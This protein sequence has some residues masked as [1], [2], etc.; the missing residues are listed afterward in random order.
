MSKKTPTTKAMKNRKSDTTCPK[1]SNSAHRVQ[2]E[3][4]YYIRCS[5]CGADTIA[6]TII[7]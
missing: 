7:K 3:G 1:C 6:K 4:R 5:W 2:N